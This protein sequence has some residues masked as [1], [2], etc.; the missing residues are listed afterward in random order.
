MIIC[1]FAFQ[2]SNISTAMA[3]E[4][5]SNSKKS[6]QASSWTTRLWFPSVT[7]F[8]LESI[9]DAFPWMDDR[10]QKIVKILGAFLFVLNVS[11]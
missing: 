9:G 1:L 8:G 2:R 4:S 11:S 5:L 7:G 6:F 10:P 3:F